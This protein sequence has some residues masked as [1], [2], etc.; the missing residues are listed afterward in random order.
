MSV[1]CNRAQDFLQSSIVCS[2]ESENIHL[3]YRP[4]I[5]FRLKEFS[6]NLPNLIKCY[7]PLPWNVWMDL[8][9]WYTTCCPIELF[10]PTKGM[11]MNIF[12]TLHLTETSHNSAAEFN[13]FLA[14]IWRWPL[15]NV[16]MGFVTV[17]SFGSLPLVSTAESACVFCPSKSCWIT[18]ASA[19]GL[20]FVL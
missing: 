7:C 15:E 13:A 3:I 17:S 5:N 16:Q 12:W 10:P 8:S 6:R 20:W 2:I 4:N 1:L 9:S 14:R 11:E 19:Y 18:S